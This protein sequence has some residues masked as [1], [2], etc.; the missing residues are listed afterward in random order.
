MVTTQSYGTREAAVA[1]KKRSIAKLLE[2]LDEAALRSSSLLAR[3]LRP[4]RENP[5]WKGLPRYLFIGPRGGDEPIRLGLFAGI[6]GDEPEGCQALAGLIQ[7][8]EKAPDLA[9]G[10]TLFI[11]PVCN[12]TGYEDNTR[13]SRRGL[14]LNREFWRGSEEDEVALLEDEIRAQAFHGMIALHSDSTSE[15]MYGFVRGAAL[16]RD[17][18]DPALAVAEEIL[19]RNQNPVIDGFPAK[20]GIIRKGYNGILTTPPKIK[21]VP[22][23]I[24]LESPQT[25]PQ[26][27]Q[28]Q[29]LLVA[30]LKIL[31]EYRKFISYAANL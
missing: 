26:F 19:P 28:E 1:P 27:L 7:T 29:A 8:L 17:L 12:P 31:S 30:T 11:Y 25:S 6:H 15:G 21:P 13:H 2:P 22:F 10:Y 18:L 16:S 3:P 5:D 14:D 4:S 20:N 9:R 23:E 24:I